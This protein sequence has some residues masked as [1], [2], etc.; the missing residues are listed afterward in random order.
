MGK[1]KVA[2]SREPSQEAPAGDPN[3]GPHPAPGLC[4]NRTPYPEVAVL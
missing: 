4:Q 3:T 1:L 2:W